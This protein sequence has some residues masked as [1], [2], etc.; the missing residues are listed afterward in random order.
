MGRYWYCLPRLHE[1][2]I[3]VLNTQARLV[4][5]FLCLLLFNETMPVKKS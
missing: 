5:A 3:Q 1:E 2:L 4:R